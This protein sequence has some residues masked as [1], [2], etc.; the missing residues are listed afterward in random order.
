MSKLDI[1]KLD[2]TEGDL[3]TQETIES[4]DTN[5]K[6]IKN[7][8]ESIEYG[9]QLALIQDLAPIADT[10]AVAQGLDTLLQDLTAKGFMEK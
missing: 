3:I 10:Q 2:L 5:M 7:R 9:E 6:R 4:I 1:I 8:L